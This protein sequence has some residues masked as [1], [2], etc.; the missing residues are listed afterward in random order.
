LAINYKKLRNYIFSVK[1]A[2]L[3]YLLFYDKMMKFYCTLP[4]C[5]RSFDTERGLF[6]HETRDPDHNPNKRYEEPPF[7]CSLSRLPNG[8]KRRHDIPIPYEVSSISESERYKKTLSGP[9]YIDADIF[10]SMIDKNDNNSNDFDNNDDD[11]DDSNEDEHVYDDGENI[12]N[13]GETQNF[14]NDEEKDITDNVNSD[15][16]QKYNLEYLK[17][18]HKLYSEIYGINTI[19]S[20]NIQQFKDNLEDFEI[21]RLAILKVYLFAKSCNMSRNNGDDLLKLI[22]NIYHNVEVPQHIPDSWKSVSRAI[23]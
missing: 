12:D 23:N 19:E 8:N 5:K 22:K 4:N 15:H 21:K 18:Q 14:Q 6:Y 9:R 17:Y 7:S 2:N 10:N 13:D 3:I 20:E 11:S 16:S 1:Q